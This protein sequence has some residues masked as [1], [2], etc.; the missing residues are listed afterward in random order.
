MAFGVKTALRR[1][2]RD[3]VMRGPQRDRL[4]HREDLARRFLRGDGIEIGAFSMPLRVPP[5][6]RVRYV[7]HASK[8]ELLARYGVDTTQPRGMPETDVIDDASTLARFGDAS[9]DFVIAAHVLEHLEDPV[10]ALEAIVRVLRPEGVAFLVLPDARF[11]FDAARERTT[12]EH[13]LADHEHG[14]ERSRRAHYEEW[15]RVIES[16]PPDRVAARADEFAAQDARHHFHVWE[17]ETFVELVLALGL[18]ARLEL[19]ERNHDEFVVV[20]RRAAQA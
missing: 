6:A 5:G 3:R 15:A 8:A 16:T 20:L 12:V 2:G 13:V 7:D 11:S 17:L 14:P 10:A 18:P 4:I 1:W 9:L 19:A